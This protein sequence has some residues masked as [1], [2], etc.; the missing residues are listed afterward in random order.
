MPEWFLPV[1][2]LFGLLSVVEVA[3]TYLATAAF[4]TSLRSAGWFHKTASRVYIL[5]SLLAFSVIILSV[6]CPEPFISAGYAV[7]IPAIPFIMLYFI[8]INLLR[9]AGK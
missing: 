4:A 2:K 7:S 5:I 6:F 9:G 8:G 1:R 3:L